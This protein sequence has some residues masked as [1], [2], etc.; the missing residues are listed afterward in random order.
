MVG[1]WRHS[2]WDLECFCVLLLSALCSLLFRARRPL[3][4]Q[5]EMHQITAQNGQIRIRCTDE[6]V[7]CHS[8][9]TLRRL[10][11]DGQRQHD[12]SQSIEFAVDSV[13]RWNL[14]CGGGVA[15]VLLFDARNGRWAEC[16]V[17]AKGET[18]S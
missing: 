15:V 10:H 16:R 17:T 3:L 5:S 18:A 7:C 11:G 2:Q 14:L 1:I 13:S 8:L 4:Y 6:R 9:W 12:G